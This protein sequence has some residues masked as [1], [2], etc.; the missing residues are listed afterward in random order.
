MKIDTSQICFGLSEQHDQQSLSIILQLAGR[1]DFSDLL[2]SR[3]NSDE[4]E[5][6]M[7]QFTGL[8]KQ[9]LTENEYHTEFLLNE[10]RHK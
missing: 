3:M 9:H 10:R 5:A 8:L 7:N 2:S 1:K 6:F 4:I